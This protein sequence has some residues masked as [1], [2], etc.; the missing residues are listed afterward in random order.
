MADHLAFN[1]TTCQIYPLSTS[2]TVILLLMC[3]LTLVGGV[4]AATA[5]ANN[6]RLYKATRYIHVSVLGST[7]L[8]GIVTVPFLTAMLNLPESFRSYSACIIA[9]S[10]ILLTISSFAFN[11]LL[12][13]ACVF[14]QVMHPFKA[15]LDETTKRFLAAAIVTWVASAVVSFIPAT[16]WNSYYQSRNDEDFFCFPIL[17]P[18]TGYFV[19]LTYCLMLP[20]LVVGYI[21]YFRAHIE[22]RKVIRQINTTYPVTSPCNSVIQGKSTRNTATLILIVSVLF[23]GWIP[24]FVIFSLTYFCVECVNPFAVLKA[25]TLIFGIVCPLG[26][27]MYCLRLKENRVVIRRIVFSC[28]CKDG[29]P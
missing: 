22:I 9:N 28:K 7:L 20:T 3:L 16:P 6:S 13:S 23:L 12:S 26:S 5:V 2:V 8:N 11:T 29:P 25:L 15:S 18:T 21:V 19:L 27:M 4:I 10:F 14:Y 24:I 17:V 1:C